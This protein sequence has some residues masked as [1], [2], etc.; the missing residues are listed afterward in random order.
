MLS[1]LSPFRN[2]MRLVLRPEP[3]EPKV[4]EVKLTHDEIKR[5]LAELGEH[6][7]SARERSTA[8]RSESLTSTGSAVR[9]ESTSRC[10]SAET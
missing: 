6:W 7:A 1:V 3:R 10:M 2:E 8:R 4:A 9:R 5:L